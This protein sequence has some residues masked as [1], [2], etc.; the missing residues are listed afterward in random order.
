MTT[1][2]CSLTL[3]SLALFACSP[4]SDVTSDATLADAGASSPASAV[5]SAPVAPTAGSAQAAVEAA[6]QAS[7][8]AQA[9]QPIIVPA[10]LI[11]KPDFA[12]LVTGRSKADIREAFGPPSNVVSLGGT[13]TWFYHADRV[14]ITDPEAG[15]V[16]HS[17]GVSFSADGVATHVIS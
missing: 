5:T 8:A 14:S 7:L 2:L 10:G 3:L 1:K 4:R 6:T 16:L 15:I 13:D 9:S 17:V 11:P 12:A